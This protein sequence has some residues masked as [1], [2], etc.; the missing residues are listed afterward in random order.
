MDAWKRSFS[1]KLAQAQAR[2]A[3][4]L[5][6]ALDSAVT[7]VFG[8]LH[9]FLQ[10]N[11]ITAATPL[12]EKGRRSYKFELSEDAYVLLLF[13]GRGVGEFELTRETFVLGQRPNVQK[14][15]ERLT[16]LTPEWVQQEFQTAL[17]D[18]VDRLVEREEAPAE[19]PLEIN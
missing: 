6:E 12:R 19:T 17:D 14:L 3:A 15:T 18:F 7:P 9:E 16:V 13:R 8:E 2:W 1:E 10:N 4:R 11:G 5:D